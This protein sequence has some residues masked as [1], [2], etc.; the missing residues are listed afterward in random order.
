VHKHSIAAIPQVIARLCH[1]AISLVS[2]DESS[3]AWS[4]WQTGVACQQPAAKY[5]PE[6]EV[7]L[8]ITKLS[9]NLISIPTAGEASAALGSALTIRGGV[10][11][12]P[13]P[14]VCDW[15][16][17]CFA[18]S[19][20]P[21]LQYQNPLLLYYIRIRNVWT[22]GLWLIHH[23]PSSPFEDVSTHGAE[24]PPS[25]V[26]DRRSRIKPAP[27]PTWFEIVC[28]SSLEGTL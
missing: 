5:F 16:I 14:R 24:Y 15:P 3:A 28:C 7:Q 25:H 10:A 2:W 21:E 18:P 1:Q 13:S 12:S 26:F 9:V 22:A 8:L 19:I 6:V 11:R 27:E 4:K 20:L 23:N 17:L